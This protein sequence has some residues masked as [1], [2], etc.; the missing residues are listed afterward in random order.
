MDLV[1]E[2]TTESY[3]VQSTAEIN[4]FDIIVSPEITNYIV[5]VAQL[6]ERGEKGDPGEVGNIDGGIIY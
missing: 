6:G 1:V 2:V 5:Q 4:K 3:V